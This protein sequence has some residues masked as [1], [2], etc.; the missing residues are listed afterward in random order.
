[1]QKISQNQKEIELDK[2]KQRILGELKCPLKDEAK[3]LV[4]GKGNPDAPILFIGEAPGAKEDELGLPFVGRAGKELDKLLNRIDLTIDD[5]YIANILKYRPPKNRDPKKEEILNHTP[6]LIEQIKIIQPKIIATLGNY[7]TKFIL[8]QCNIDEMKKISGIAE[9]HGQK[10]NV[11]FNGFEFLV[12]PIYHPSAMMY[13]PKVRV[14]F[15]NDF[16]IMAEIIGK[17]FK[18]EEIQKKLI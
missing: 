5:V 13:N 12:I 2:I 8:S 16:K 11:K 1:M 15:E 9:I 17:K 18:K 10:F 14:E 3:N 6:Y 4:F 7:S